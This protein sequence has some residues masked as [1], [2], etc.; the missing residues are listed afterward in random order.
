MI[1]F[2]SATDPILL[3]DP[4]FDASSVTIHQ[5]LKGNSSFFGH[6]TES[7]KVNIGLSI[8]ESNTSLSKSSFQQHIYDINQATSQM[9][10]SSQVFQQEWTASFDP[11]T[12]I[13][14]EATMNYSNL[15]KDAYLKFDVE[16]KRKVS[17]CFT[18]AKSS[19]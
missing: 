17:S 2:C 12:R 15:D 10:N 8:A 5:Y 13:R 6:A 4:L 3:G 9:G 7:G 16:I 1:A 18:N 11:Q 14:R 19:I